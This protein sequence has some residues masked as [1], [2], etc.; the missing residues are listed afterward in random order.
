M[1]YEVMEVEKFGLVNSFANRMKPLKAI[2]VQ[3]HGKSVPMTDIYTITEMT[4]K[5]FRILTETR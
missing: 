3:G 1:V 4:D 2:S 5:L